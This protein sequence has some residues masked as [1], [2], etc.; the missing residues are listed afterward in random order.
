MSKYR[1]EMGGIIRDTEI[2]FPYHTDEII[3]LLE[4]KDQQ[5]AELEAKLA[6]SEKQVWALENQ[7]LHAHNCLNKLKQQLAEKNKENM[8]LASKVDLLESEKENLFRTLEEANE[9]NQDKISFCIEQLS[10]TRNFVNGQEI[11]SKF[12]CES[13]VCRDILQAIDNQIN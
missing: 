9:E 12:K 13:K 1:Y 10:K 2:D 3:E 4:E 7:K 6:E 8:E 5:I 11:F